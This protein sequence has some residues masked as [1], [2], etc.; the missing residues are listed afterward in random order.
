MNQP[1]MFCSKVYIWLSLNGV[2][3]MFSRKK[4]ENLIFRDVMDKFL[5][6]SICMPLC[7]FAADDTKLKLLAGPQ[8][9]GF[10]ANIVHT[11]RHY[12]TTSVCPSSL[13]IV[14][15]P[16]NG[17]TSLAQEI[18]LQA[19]RTY[20]EYIPREHEQDE[21]NHFMSSQVV[22]ASP[23]VTILNRLHLLGSNTKIL[24][25]RMSKCKKNKAL[26]VV[27]ICSDRFEDENVTDLFTYRMQLAKPDK[28]SRKEILEY[29][30]SQEQYRKYITHMADKT[31]GVSSGKIKFLADRLDVIVDQHDQRTLSKDA[32]D[33]EL[34]HMTYPVVKHKRNMKLYIFAASVSIPIALHVWDG[35]AR[36]WFFNEPQTLRLMREKFV[37]IIPY[38]FELIKL[39]ML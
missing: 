31:E 30:L 32:L 7:I 13:L 22:K 38:L 23:H 8:E 28:L 2:L 27:G 14:G 39:N 37:S 10:V 1:S 36:T 20:D 26:F 15:P 24:G 16:F 19:G 29:Y 18:A 3:S 35:V 33:Q 17:K 11:L 12:K 5:L 25:D 34:S 4:I 6:L 21:L 9:R